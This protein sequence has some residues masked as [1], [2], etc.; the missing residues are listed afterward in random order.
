M[1]ENQNTATGQMMMMKQAAA[2]NTAIAGG[3]LGTPSVWHNT[4]VPPPPQLAVYN[5]KVINISLEECSN[6]TIIRIGNV[7]R[8]CPAGADLYKEIGVAHAES[9]L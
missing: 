2:Q 7:V 1:D 9:Q 8:I 6:G 4:A 5:K 3:L